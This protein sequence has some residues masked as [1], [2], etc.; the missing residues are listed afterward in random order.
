MKDVCLHQD[1]VFL[2]IILIIVKQKYLLLSREK[3]QKLKFQMENL[4]FHRVV[5]TSD[6]HVKFF[7]GKMKL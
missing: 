4:I 6:L 1:F 5:F 7:L 2:F 3:T